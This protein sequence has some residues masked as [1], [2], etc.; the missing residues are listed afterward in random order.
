MKKSIFTAWV[1]DFGLSLVLTAIVLFLL[2]N[3]RGALASGYKVYDGA[4]SLVQLSIDTLDDRLL[5]V[6]FQLDP[7]VT[8]GEIDFNLFDGETFETVEQ[9][10]VEDGLTPWEEG[11]AD[12]Y[13]HTV[14]VPAG[15]PDPYRMYLAL[16][17][18]GLG[19]DAFTLIHGTIQLKSV[20]FDNCTHMAG[21][22][23]DEYRVWTH[24]Q[25]A[26][27]PDEPG[28]EIPFAVYQVV[29]NGE[30]LESVAVGQDSVAITVPEPGE[31]TFRIRAAAS[32]E[33]EQE[34]L[35]SSSNALEKTIYWP[36]LDDLRIELVDVTPEEE[37]VVRI[38]A[39][40]SYTDYE[41][42]LMRR[43]AP[44]ADPEQVGQGFMDPGNNALQFADAVED[45]DAAPWHYHVEAHVMDED[46][47]CPEPAVVSDP[48]STLWFAAEISE[49]SDDQL[50][51]DIRFER[52]PPAGNYT[53]QQIL[54][55]ESAYQDGATDIDSPYTHDLSGELPLAGEM[56]FRMKGEEGGEEFHSH[57]VVFAI[58]PVINIPN[59]FRPRVGEPDNLEFYPSFVGFDADYI[60]TIY[61]RNGLLIFSGDS[62]REWDGQ[63]DNGGLA[64]EGAYW[65]H[66]RYTPTTPGVEPGEKRG[67]V[68]LIR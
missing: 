44:G 42:R 35:F 3:N 9:L 60:L 6:V 10:R 66:I 68:Y 53:L 33:A 57:E 64:P 55:G 47:V 22:M 27:D 17:E 18:D 49:F 2:V 39:D 65:Y 62:N 5:H 21:F 54:P 43:S 13:I 30:V 59:A 31:Y 34:G 46:E 40:G 48:V 1:K 56:R 4:I 38:A 8:D 14:D 36:V 52:V 50:T 24:S 26:N 37:V 23:W 32:D 7:G 51:V 61:D 41:Y 63:M 28:E 16:D 11:G 19:A 45:L 67:V 20:T 29:A 12:Q 25:Y 58:D 15:Y